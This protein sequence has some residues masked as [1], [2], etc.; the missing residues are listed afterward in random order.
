MVKTPLENGGIEL[1]QILNE[2]R[3]HKLHAVSVRSTHSLEL[4]KVVLGD[5]HI[6]GEPGCASRP[7][8]ESKRLGEPLSMLWYAARTADAV[9]AKDP[10]AFRGRAL[11]AIR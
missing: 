11:L 5:G 6:A 4:P 8:R 10:R 7:Y 2:V 9:P 1:L 3:V